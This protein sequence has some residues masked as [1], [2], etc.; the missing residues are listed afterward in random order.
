MSG[1]VKSLG[2]HA[3]AHYCTWFGC[4]CVCLSPLILALQ[5]PSRL[6]SDTNRSIVVDRPSALRSPEAM[7]LLE[8]TPTCLVTCHVTHMHMLILVSYT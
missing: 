8:A 5:G 4:L 1:E 2:A 3:H 7:Q 6:I